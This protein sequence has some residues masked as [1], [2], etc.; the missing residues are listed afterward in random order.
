MTDPR[1][2]E[3]PDLERL[4][5]FAAGRLHGEEA[6]RIAGHLADCPFCSLERKRL[7]RFAAIEEDEELL[8]EADWPRAELLL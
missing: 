4:A 1:H 7:D 5:E 2:G 8:A 3:H 6:E